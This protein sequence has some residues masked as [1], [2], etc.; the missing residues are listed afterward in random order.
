MT[1]LLRN[2]LLLGPALL[3]LASC[4]STPKVLVSKELTR[5]CPDPS[6]YENP[7]PSGLTDD[8]TF[9]EIMVS[10]SLA[11]GQA[12]RDRE[13]VHTYCKITED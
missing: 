6:L 4:A 5:V 11:L 10:L 12:N 9:E 1:Q 13:Q 8:M 2:V 7:I 3:L